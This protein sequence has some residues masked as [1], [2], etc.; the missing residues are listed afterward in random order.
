MSIIQPDFLLPFSWS[1]KWILSLVPNLPDTYLSSHR[2]Q[3]VPEV[4][5]LNAFII[6]IFDNGLAKRNDKKGQ[7]EREEREP[8]LRN[9]QPQGDSELAIVSYLKETSSTKIS[10]SIFKEKGEKNVLLLPR[11]FSVHTWNLSNQMNFR[12]TEHI[13]LLYA[14]WWWLNFCTVTQPDLKVNFTSLAPFHRLKS[15]F[16]QHWRSSGP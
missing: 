4:T 8:K 12:L 5:N 2:F 3:K 1:S 13:C 7:Q 9:N 6:Q 10:K 11:T 16:T 14:N 15:C